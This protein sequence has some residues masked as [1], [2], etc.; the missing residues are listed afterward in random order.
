[1]GRNTFDKLVCL[2]A[3]DPIFE[4]QGK[5]PQRH[6]KVQLAAFLLRYGNCGSNTFIVERNLNISEGSVFDYCRRVVK[7]VRRLC[8]QF[9]GWPGESCKTEISQYIENQSGFPNCI[10]CCDGS[11]IRFTEEPMVNG[12]QYRCRKKTWAVRTSCI[13]LL[14]TVY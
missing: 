4:S 12:D 7:A 8:S 13:S 14:I 3:D 2:L 1:M 9:L 10:G 11:L 5:K 6:V